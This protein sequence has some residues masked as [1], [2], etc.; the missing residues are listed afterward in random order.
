MLVYK[1]HVHDMIRQ[2]MQYLLQ[3][4]LTQ[5]RLVSIKWSNTRCKSCSIFCK[6]LKV[7]LSILWTSGFIG[8]TPS[9]YCKAI[10]WFFTARDLIK[11][12]TSKL[13]DKLLLFDKWLTCRISTQPPFHGSLLFASLTTDNQRF[14]LAWTFQFPGRYLYFLDR[15]FYYISH[16]CE[17]NIK[18]SEH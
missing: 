11:Y 5:R 9:W 18:W 8:L 3:C 14:L 6:I 7:C 4:A 13:K 16:F 12:L 10:G 1:M 15:L 2:M 17:G